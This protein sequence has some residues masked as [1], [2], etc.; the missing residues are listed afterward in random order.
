MNISL[1]KKTERERTLT[2][3]GDGMRA[4]L[5]E[6]PEIRTYNVNESGQRGGVSARA[7]WMWR[8]TVT[9]FDTTDELAQQVSDMM[10]TL[11]G[12]SEV[13]ISRDSTRPEYHV[14]FDREKLSL[15]G[16]DVTTAAMYL[17]N[18]INGSVNSYYRE[19]GDEY[20]IRVR[21]DRQFRESIEDIENITIYNSPRVRASGCVTWER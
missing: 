21:Y 7:R 6:Y 17:R 14:D 1:L 13:T 18:R 12:C 11:P 5:N 15:N 2:E 20:D 4:I 19:D 16:L 3:I 10:R 9:I 8:S